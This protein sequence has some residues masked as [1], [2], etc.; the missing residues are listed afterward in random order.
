MVIDHICFAVPDIQAAITYWNDVFGYRQ[1][2][3][4]VT[5]TLQGVRVSF[6]VKEES[7]PIK[8]I[9][10]VPDNAALQKAVSRGG[11]FH[12]ICFKCD[13]VEIEI[14]NLSAKGLRTLVQP[15]PGEAFNNHA[16]AFMRA[17]YGLNFELIDTDERAGLL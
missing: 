7:L 2:T 5:N 17:R 15:Q 3:G 1:S 6:L 16:I 8:L 9:E 10:P 12:H 11:G 4:I 14:D 13:D